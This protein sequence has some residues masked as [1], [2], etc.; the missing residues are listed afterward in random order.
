MSIIR[1][2]IATTISMIVVVLSLSVVSPN[3]AIGKG[4]KRGPRVTGASVSGGKRL[5]INGT[6]FDPR[7]SLRSAASRTGHP[8]RGTNL[9]VGGAGGAGSLGL[10]DYDGHP[11]TTYLRK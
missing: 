9:L 1:R 2:S 11:I 4:N 7:T 6:G 8:K 3:T 5:T 10:L